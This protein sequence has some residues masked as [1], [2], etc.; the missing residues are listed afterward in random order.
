M[1]ALPQS[2]HHPAK[3]HALRACVSDIELMMWSNYP[4]SEVLPP[5]LRDASNLEETEAL[6]L[7]PRGGQALEAAPG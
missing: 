1:Y 7:K 4:R 6:A 3:Q 5:S 2:Q